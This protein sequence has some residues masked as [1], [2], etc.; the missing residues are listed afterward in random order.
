MFVQNR[1]N[2]KDFLYLRDR[3]KS[4]QFPEIRV[5]KNKT[6]QSIL[7]SDTLMKNVKSAK[8]LLRVC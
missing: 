1:Q 7:G 6:R 5:S 4:K 2:F 3:P 8:G